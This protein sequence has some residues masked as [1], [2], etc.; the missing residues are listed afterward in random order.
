MRYA[1]VIVWLLAIGGAC[2]TAGLLVGRSSTESGNYGAYVLISAIVATAALVTAV[3]LSLRLV[4]S[5]RRRR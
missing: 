5:W 3:L 1:W 4:A 2:F